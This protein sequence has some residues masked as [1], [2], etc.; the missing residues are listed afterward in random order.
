MPEF[1]QTFTITSD[2]LV[3]GMYYPPLSFSAVGVRLVSCWVPVTWY[4]VR[5]SWDTFT[6]QN[7]F[8][9]SAP[10]THTVQL[11]HGTYDSTSMPV[12]LANAI[13]GSVSGLVSSITIDPVTGKLT[14]HC[15]GGRVLPTPFAELIGFS[16]L[17]PSSA[18]NALT[19]GNVVQLA[20]P[21]QAIHLRSRSLGF[22]IQGNYHS[23]LG[24]RNG[25]VASVFID[26]RFG[27]SM[28]WQNNSSEYYMLNR[29]SPVPIDSF[30]LEWVDKDWN[31]ISFNGS[32]WVV[33]LAFI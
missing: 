22:E 8:I 24:A 20:M 4:S 25:I 7:D 18:A 16:S 12:V 1:Y 13:N 10:T 26:K 30:D 17:I 19:G 32:S 21:E 27:E 23:S 15:A 2:D 11:P 14:I 28:A 3:A 6:F 33:T 5:D 29:G 9:D 31:P